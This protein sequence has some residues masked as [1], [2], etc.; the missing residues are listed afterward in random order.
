MTRRRRGRGNDSAGCKGTEAVDG[1]IWRH[2]A[3]CKGTE[4]D[5]VTES[6]QLGQQY[7]AEPCGV[8][9]KPALILAEKATAGL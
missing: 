2:A 3:G 7:L 6:V 5:L 9:R 1:P 8:L 4:A